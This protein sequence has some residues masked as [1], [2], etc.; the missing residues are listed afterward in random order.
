MHSI[1]VQD[2]LPQM[3]QQPM[4]Y[5]D[6]RQPVEPAA[7]P[8]PVQ[9]QQLGAPLVWTDQPQ[10]QQQQLFDQNNNAWSDNAILPGAPPIDDGN[11][12]QASYVIDENAAPMMYW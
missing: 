6:F 2:N 12:L 3:W 8:P 5:N 10:Q 1:C 9:Q 7:P 11:R 4:Q